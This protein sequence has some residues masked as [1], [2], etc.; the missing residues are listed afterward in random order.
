MEADRLFDG[1]I[2]ALGVS[3]TMMVAAIILLL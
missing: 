1:L 2:V 3:S